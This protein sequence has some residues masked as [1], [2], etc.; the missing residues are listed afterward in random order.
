MATTG[1][2]PKPFFFDFR[3]AVSMV[4]ESPN[5]LELQEHENRLRPPTHD[6]H[7]PP[8]KHTDSPEHSRLCAARHEFRTP[9]STACGCLLPPTKAREQPT[10]TREH[11]KYP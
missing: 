8:M 2:S 10:A 7:R 6:P 3:A 4:H 11:L 1:T 9:L 5:G